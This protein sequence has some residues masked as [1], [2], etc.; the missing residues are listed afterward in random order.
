MLSLRLRPLARLF[1]A[2]A[3]P[4]ALLPAGDLTARYELSLRR[5]ETGASPRFDVPF[6]TAD[7]VPRH[8]RRFTEFSGDVSGRYLD[9]MAAA[10]RLNGLPL[11]RWQPVLDEVLR[12][13][14]PDG[15]FGADFP[16][17]EATDARMAMLWGNGRMLIGLEE[18]YAATNQSRVLAAARRLG[19]FLLAE[20]PLLNSPS[21]L[22]RFNDGKAAVGYICWTQNVEG[23]TRLYSLTRDERYLTLARDIAGRTSFR[24]GQHSHGH[25]ASLRGIVMLWEAT[26]EAR[27][28]A[29]AEQQYQAVIDSGN[30]LPEGAVPELYLPRMKRDEGCSEAD[31]LRL[32]LAL[33][34]ATG[35][36]A[37]L[38]RAER[39]LFNELALNQFSDG[40]FGHRLRSEDEAAA[41]PGF[42][43]AGGAA[44]AW[45]CCL[46]HGLRALEEVLAAAFVEQ[47][48][49]TAFILPVDG[50][51]H[52]A[53]V[54]WISQSRLDEDGTIELRVAAASGAASA[55]R[56]R[57]PEWARLDATLNGQPAGKPDGAW[58]VLEHA[59]QTGD[60][61]LLRYHMQTRL[62]SYPVSKPFERLAGRVLLFHGP[63]LLA[64]D[65]DTSP[66]FFDEPSSENRL[67]L[68]VA[69]PEAGA[70]TPLTLTPAPGS[71]S[72]HAVSGARFLIDYLPGGYPLQPQQATLRPLSEQTGGDSTAWSFLFA[73]DPARP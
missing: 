17:S 44:H 7:A 28:L 4:A 70:S 41:Q 59:W 6:V 53:G 62:E 11:S 45:W 16:R 50:R 36:P 55:L 31:W 49:A 8:V 29:Q 72:P 9:A 39:V 38:A 37:Y 61:I 69:R 24:P 23:L 25:L 48:G 47:H 32:S 33:Y 68:P 73:V 65:R 67:R 56:I 27:F 10:S 2:A 46:F 5:V 12:L 18:A 22:Q 51:G 52:S 63:W 42:V 15:H 43:S 64:V 1:C 54:D 26:G 57:L 40:D 19:D 66:R 58:L 14:K 60:R 30:L 3:L 20:A 34:R 71:T 21:T 35:K 13:Q